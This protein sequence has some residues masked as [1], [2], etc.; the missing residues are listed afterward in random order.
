MEQPMDQ[1]DLLFNAFLELLPVHYGIVLDAG[2][3]RLILISHQVING[4][5]TAV[6]AYLEKDTQ[7][8]H[9]TV[10][11]WIPKEEDYSQLEENKAYEP[12]EITPPAMPENTEDSTDV[13]EAVQDIQKRLD[14]IFTKRKT[15]E[16]DT[17]AQDKARTNR[18]LKFIRGE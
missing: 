8:K 5:H 16:D 9:G 12:T 1:N 2:E 11:Q 18:I 15:Q 13:D 14:E 17:R 6:T 7:H 4:E 3:D 10:L